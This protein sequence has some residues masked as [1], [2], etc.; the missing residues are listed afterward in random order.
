MLYAL[1]SMLY[2]LC[3]MPYA[4]LLRLCFGY[5]QPPA[6]PPAHHSLLTTHHSPLT[7]HHSPL[8]RSMPYAFITLQTNKPE[9]NAYCKKQKHMNQQFPQSFSLL[10]CHFHVLPRFRYVLKLGFPLHKRFAKL[11]YI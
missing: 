4:S 11:Q 1:C 10:V 9:Y 2:A 5:A 7:T 8:F 3:S 6:Q